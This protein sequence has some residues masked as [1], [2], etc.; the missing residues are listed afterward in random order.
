[1]SI[2]TNLSI[3]ALIAAITSAHAQAA[4][5][6][7]G[8]IQNRVKSAYQKL[9]AAGRLD[10]LSPEFLDIYNNMRNPKRSY[11]Q[12]VIARVLQEA[13]MHAPVKRTV[14]SQMHLLGNRN[15]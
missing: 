7:N 9:E 6:V 12:Q 15:A 14:G 2:K 13:G 1:M 5:Q 8:F 3:I 4:V 11:S 10:E